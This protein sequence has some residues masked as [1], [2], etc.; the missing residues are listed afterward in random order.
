MK[1]VIAGGSG[2]LGTL[3]AES[4]HHAGV[5]VVVL[6]RTPSLQPWRTV[7]WD[8][9]TPGAWTAELDHTDAV[10][11]LAGRSVDCRYTAA[12][13]DAILRSR[14]ESTAAIG[15]AITACAHPP[16]VWIQ[17][18]TATIYAHRYDAPNDEYTHLLG[19][20]EP[21]APASWHF[22][23]EVAKAWEQTCNAFSLPHTRKVLTRTAIVMAP[24]K[25]GA[26][27]ALRRLALL[28]LGGRFGDGRQFMSWIHGRDYV[29]AIQFLITR[30]D[31]SGIVNVAAPHPIPNERFMREL[32]EA[33][34]PPL[35]LP[36]PRWMLELGAFVIRSESELLLKSRRVIPA[37]LTENG[38]TFL[39]PRWA[40][41]ARDLC[42]QETEGG[43]RCAT[44]SS[45]LW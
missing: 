31:I 24:G 44:V 20:N 26:F 22:S 8:G 12:N 7:A 36:S 35:A 4:F 32:T 1:I 10:I 18:S 6:S 39:H 28:G 25:G 45:P 30:D 3:L 13:R 21:D 42:A 27:H 5:E 33:V 34:H 23:I 29:R 11:N 9:H 38:F 19:G 43:T 17:S 15:A 14:I 37:R 16:R 2:H 41:A 40:E